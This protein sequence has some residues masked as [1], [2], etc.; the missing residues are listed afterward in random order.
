[1]RVF[2]ACCVLAAPLAAAEAPAVSSPDGRVEFRVLTAAGGDLQYTVTFNRKP[3]IETS[4]AGIVVDKVDLASGVEIGK[5]ER[6]KISEKYPWYGNKSTAVDECNGTRIAVTHVKSRTHYT[7]E[8]RAYDSGVAFRLVVPG[9]GT[10]VPDEGTAFRLPAGATLWYH[11]LEDHYE[12][13]HVRKSLRAI[14]PGQWLA[15]PVTILLPDRAGYA[16]IT[17]GALRNYSGMALQAD[18]AGVLHARLGHAVPASYPFRLRYAADV[19]RLAA[20]APVSGTITTPWRIVMVGA[21]LN[22]LVNSDI[23][24]NVAPPPDPKLFPGG[25]RTEWVKPG[26]SLWSYLDGGDNTPEGMKEFA[27]LAAELGFEYNLLEGFWSRWPESRLKEVAEYSRQRG[28]GAIIWRH[29]NQLRT[30]E[31]RRA[32]FEMCRRTGVAGVKIDF[33]DHEHKEVIDLYEELL[34]MAAEY[35]LIV[36]FHGANKPTGMERTWPNMLGLEGIRGMEMRPPYAQHEVT[37]PFTRMLAGLADYTP[38]HFGVRKMAD[39]TWAHQVANAILLPAPLLVYAA[40]PANLLGNPMVEMIKSIPSVWDETVVLPASEPGE[41]AAL[42]R[43]KGGTW[44]LAVNNGVYAR[45]VRVDLSFL[46]QG[47][48]TSL[49][50]R[51]RGP[52]DEVKIEHVTAR[53][54]DSLYI[55]MRSGGGF[56][57][58]FAK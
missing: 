6:Y 16:A 50:V 19:E 33:F 46:G 22:A 18:A 2:L 54:G 7:L 14:P 13:Q 5:L 49:L 51:D 41:V 4:P 27:R 47:S 20:P 34:R 44:F 57:G 48:Y 58:R 23:V 56:V 30:P 24:H 35:K 1:M 17:E 9:E 36:D 45:T 29:S 53:S 10:R 55:E 26:R 8:A 31:N 38:T 25:I 32:F 52:A 11:D 43:R 15:P 3:V 37:L 40:H 42:A 21:D 28:V 39:T 12:A